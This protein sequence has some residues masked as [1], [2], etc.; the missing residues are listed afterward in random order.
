MDK[1]CLT[2]ACLL[3]A[4]WAA[5]QSPDDPF[6][7]PIPAT[8]GVIRVS[9]AEFAS[10]PDVGGEAA[11]M[12]LLVDEPGTAIA[13]VMILAFGVA[14]DFAWKRRLTRASAT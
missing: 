6:P 14:I 9:Y 5:A 3:T 4:S 7:E 1:T 2:L 12:M 10:I 11:R 13:M 8:E